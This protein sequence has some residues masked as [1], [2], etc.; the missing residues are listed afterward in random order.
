[1]TCHCRR[2]SRTF[3]LGGK[4]PPH[5]YSKTSKNSFT[6]TSKI[7]S[8]YN[9]SKSNPTR[10]KCRFQ[11]RLASHAIQHRA[12]VKR[13]PSV[14]PSTFTLHHHH[15]CLLLSIFA[16]SPAPFFVFCCNIIHHITHATCHFL[17][18]CCLVLCSSPHFYTLRIV[19]GDERNGELVHTRMISQKR[20]TGEATRRSTTP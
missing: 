13:L 20:W 18:M 8:K 17:M 12:K 1:M 3:F 11:T 6:K 14:H 9:S 5:V 7:F 15:L 16:T 19:E 10:L 2:V 4:S